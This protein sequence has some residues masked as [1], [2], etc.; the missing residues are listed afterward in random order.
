[1]TTQQTQHAADEVLLGFTRALRAAGIEPDTSQLASLEPSVQ[2]QEPAFE[3]LW[4]A[5][6]Q[7][8]RMSFTY[9]GGARRTLEPWGLTSTKGRWYV[10]GRDTD[11]DAVRMFKLSRISDVPRRASKPGAYQ[12]P[13]DLDLRSLAKSLAPEV[14]VNAIAPGWIKTMWGES[15]SKYWEA[16]ATGESQLGRWGTPEDVALAAVLL[17]SPAARFIHGQVLPVNGGFNHSPLARR[18]ES[19]A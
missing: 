2:A 15:T 12:V 18:P 10:I 4:N 19:S 5:V 11:R 17:C 16:R 8:I 14:R 6:L 13:D 7:R 9:R 3:P 1:V